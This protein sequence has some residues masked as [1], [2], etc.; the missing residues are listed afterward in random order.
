MIQNCVFLS[1]QHESAPTVRRLALELQ[2]RGIVPWVDKLP[3]GFAAGDGSVEEARRIIRDEARAF[4]LYLTKKA[5][6]SSFIR[7]IEIPEAMARRKHQPS[8][9]VFVAS[10]QYEFREIGALTEK[11]F[12]FSFGSFHGYSLDAK[13]GE[14]EEDFLIRVARATLDKHLDTQVPADRERIEIQVS[15]REVLQGTANE[16]LRIDA[17]DLLGGMVDNP[18]AWARFLAGLRDAKQQIAAR[19]SRPRLLVNGSK[20]FTSA[21]MTGRV[22]NRFPLDIRQTATEF[23]RSDGEIEAVE[24]FTI[25][26]EPGSYTTRTLLVELATGE[27]DTRAGVDALIVSGA[28]ANGGRLALR[29]TAGRVKVDERICRSLAHHVYSHIDHAVNTKKTD[30]LHLFVAAPQS[31]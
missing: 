7:D 6:D 10:P 4:L 24:G 21:F 20:H 1:H 29:P 31:L 14:S 19:Y 18:E 8:F 30:E 25:G 11:R 13:S 16:L 28:L 27:K 17:T 15:S 12:G 9:P 22:F 23:W 2:V 3:G 5:L 26:Y